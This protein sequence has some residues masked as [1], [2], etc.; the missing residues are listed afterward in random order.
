MTT[1]V[2]TDEQVTI[3]NKKLHPRLVAKRKGSNNKELAYIEGYIAIAQANL[4]F[5]YGNWGYRPLSCEQTVLLDPLSGE[6]VGI[7]YKAQ[8]ELTVAG[9]ITPIVEVGSQPVAV[10][11]VE[12]QI[13]TRRLNEARYSKPPKAMEEGPF[14][15]FEKKSARAVIVESHEQAEK[16]AVTDALK[17]CLR[18]YGEQFGNGL[19]G[20]TRVSPDDIHPSAAPAPQPQAERSTGSGGGPAS[21]ARVQRTPAAPASQSAQA[22]PDRSGTPAPQPQAR[23]AASS[24]PAQAERS[25]APAL[26]DIPT[27]TALVKEIDVLRI[28]RKDP[29]TRRV[30]GVLSAA[31]VVKTAFS[32]KDIASAQSF[33]QAE[34]TPEQ[35]AKLDKRLAPY[36]STQVP[37]Q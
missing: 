21:S 24:T 18:V 8:V 2:F 9:C 19:Y 12:E 29:Q 31:Q 15:F 3:L 36:R 27:K 11:S 1:K 28:P 25:T 17:R 7:S 10:W 30:V 14:T 32:L 13:M 5:G 22:E 20:D 4:I 35:C 33:I 26:A 16:G 37:A 6:A 34:W 23:A